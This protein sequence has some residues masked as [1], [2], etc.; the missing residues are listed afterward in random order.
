[1][2]ARSTVCLANILEQQAAKFTASRMNGY[3]KFMIEAG[4]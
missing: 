1:M 4:K 3:A 2:E